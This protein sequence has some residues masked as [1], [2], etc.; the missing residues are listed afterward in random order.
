M[1]APP[2]ECNLKQKSVHFSFIKLLKKAFEGPNL[3]N[4]QH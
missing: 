3:L 1:V 4:K 2:N